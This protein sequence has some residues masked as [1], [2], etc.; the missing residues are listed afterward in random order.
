MNHPPRWL[1]FLF[2]PAVAIIAMVLMLAGGDDS[3][4]AQGTHVP[5]TPAP[6]RTTPVP[7]VT[8]VPIMDNLAPDLPLTNFAG[9]TFHLYDLEGQIVVVNFW[10][11][12]C[13]PCVKEMP[14]L[15]EV[16]QDYPQVIVLGVT[17]PEDGQ[18]IDLIQQ[19]IADYGL[20]NMQ[21]GLDKNSL[22]Q[23]NFNA[24]QLPMTFVLDR[25]GYVR[26]RQI[27]EVTRE[28]LEYYIDELSS[29]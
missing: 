16:A 9:D 1:V 8:I 7:T 3:R 24:L 21:F 4:I 26:F 18:N 19:F 6:I 11:T 14:L 10:A 15:Q 5:P 13:P 17:N 28:D 2:F 22:L 25:Q 20:N 29:S 27:G 23:L 12:W